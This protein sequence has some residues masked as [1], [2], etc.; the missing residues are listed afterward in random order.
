MNKNSREVFGMNDVV[1]GY[2]E[3]SRR[4][5]RRLGRVVSRWPTE[6]RARRLLGGLG[7]PVGIQ[8]SIPES[9]GWVRFDAA[10]LPGMTDVIKRLQA[11]GQKWVNEERH[12]GQTSLPFG[13]SRPQDL[14]AHPELLEMALQEDVLRAVGWYLRQVPRLYSV[15]IWWSPPNQTVKGSQLFHY[16]HR[17]TRQAK[18]F[19]N[20]NDVGAESGPLH[21]LSADQAARFNR[22]VGYSQDRITDEQVYSV[23]SPNE[24]KTTA[25]P[26]GSGF[27]V[28]TAR[29]LHYGSRG[30][31]LGRL[32][33]MANYV[34]ANC[35]DPGPKRTLDHVRDQLRQARYADDPVRAYVLTA[36]R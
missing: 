2:V 1:A 7:Q 8:L 25:G 21:F 28:D 12:A 35:V 3:I 16:D 11:L 14:L 32:V 36:P 4:S 9:A 29:C 27:I 20:L 23:V 22:M 18:L 26:A 10:G 31:K 34:R 33:F 13:L 19:I 6:L 17:D 30:N 24:V 5:M 15:E